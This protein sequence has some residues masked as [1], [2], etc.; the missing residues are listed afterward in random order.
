MNRKTVALIFVLMANIV[1]LAHAVVPHHHHN[2]VD[3]C[4][5]IDAGSHRHGDVAA[6]PH[7]S[8]DHGTTLECIIGD[9]IVRGADD[10]L[11]LALSE[12]HPVLDI[13]FY[14]VP[15][16]ESIAL[17][18]MEGGHAFAPAQEV[19]TPEVFSSA[20]GLRA[21]PFTVTTLA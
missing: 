11:G 7:A 16:A 15:V 10:R 12:W 19:H 9:I 1:L 21:P 18:L 17:E 13:D 2:P 4:L 20:F 5:A 6:D 3:V 14:I 8:H